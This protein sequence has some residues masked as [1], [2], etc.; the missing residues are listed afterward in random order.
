MAKKGKKHE[1]AP[2]SLSS[3]Y[4]ASSATISAPAVPIP[5]A[6]ASVPTTTSYKPITDDVSI[7]R[8]VG[9][10]K[11]SP[12]DSALGIVWRHAFEEG[13]KLGYVEGA[14]LFE[15]VDIS[16]G[17]KAAA[18]RGYEKG[19]EEGRNREKRAW[20]AAGHSTTCITVARPPR[21]VAVQTEN[22]PPRSTAT[23]K[24]DPFQAGYNE[25]RRDEQGDWLI[26]GHVQANTSKPPLCNVEVQANVPRSITDSAVQTTPPRSVMTTAVQADTPKILPTTPLAPRTVD[27][28]MQTNSPGTLDT[29]S[30][31]TLHSGPTPDPTR[32]TSPPSPPLNWADDAA[33]LPISSL[34]ILSPPI[35]SSHLTPRDL[36]ILRSSFSKPFSSLQRRNKRQPH[37]SQPFCKRQSFNIPHQTSSRHRF[38]PPHFSTTSVKTARVYPSRTPH[39]SPSSA[40]NWEGD[41]RLFKLSQALNALGWVRP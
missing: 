29:S 18:E 24:V 27:A 28:S 41:P 15:G 25:G 37:F 6:P 36:S 1:S 32:I 22:V 9:L 5:L 31:A 39:F 12:P 7:E 10:A 30:Q 34:P 35:L 40:L 4:V 2:T 26:E 17:M 13:K 14:K 8:L 20:G 3:N 23:P 38:P 11:D 21:G 19:I 33:S 16:E